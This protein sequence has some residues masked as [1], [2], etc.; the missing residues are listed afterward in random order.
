M[1]T[2]YK[3]ILALCFVILESAL[4]TIGLQVGGAAIGAVPLL[5]YSSIVGIA[6]MFIVIYYQDRGRALKVFLKDR[7]G[8]IMLFLTGLFGFGVGTLALTLGTLETTPSMS[9]I[10]YRTYPLIIAVLTPLTLRHRVSRKQLFALLLGFVGVGIVLS[11]GSLTTIN[12]SELPYI[13]LVLFAALTTAI[14]TLSIKAY[15]T[16]T[17]AYTLLGNVSSLFLTVLLILIFHI[18]VPISLSLPAIL[19]IFL[20]GGIELGVGCVLFYYCYKIFSTA[21]AGLGMLTIPFLTVILSFVLL[22]TEIH[23]YYFVAAGILT[24]GILL[25]EGKILNAPELLKKRDALKHIQIYDVTSAFIENSTIYSYIR[26]G[27]RALAIRSEVGKYRGDAHEH[28]FKKK[29]CIVFTNLKPHIA[30]RR[31]EIDFINEMVGFRE[32]EMLLIAVGEPKKIES[33]FEEFYKE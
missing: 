28:L 29:D 25:Q 4:V 14:S 32:G 15:N 5:F 2:L 31:E 26:G 10:V 24:L 18:S 6:T 3:G 17:T 13:L 19:S 33:A 1:E 23:I 9:A 16:S 30:V 21:T 7:K 8:L 20:I 22:G 27:G 11:N 12:F